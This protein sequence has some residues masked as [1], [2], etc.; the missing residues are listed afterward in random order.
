MYGEIYKLIHNV[1]FR[2][3]TVFLTDPRMFPVPA[4]DISFFPKEAR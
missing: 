3:F 1:P 2:H 4:R